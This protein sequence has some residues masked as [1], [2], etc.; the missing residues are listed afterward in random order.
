MDGDASGAN[1]GASWAD[2][3]TDLQSALK[4]AGV[5]EG[6][7]VWVAQ[8]VYTPGITYT[9]TFSIPAGVAIYG[10]FAATETERTQRD[11]VANVTVLSGDIDHNDVTNAGSVVHDHR[12]ITGTNGSH[13]VWLDGYSTPSTATT[14]LDESQLLGAAHYPS[15]I[16][17]KEACGGGSTAAAVLALPVAPRLLTP[18]SMAITDLV[19]ALFAAAQSG[20]SQHCQTSF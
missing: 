5:G 18:A 8:G 1:T 14:R 11:W 10:G 4:Q 6:T 13:V 12:A 17:E 16:I 2:A 9:A 15:M 20:P 3:Y 19:A 7:E